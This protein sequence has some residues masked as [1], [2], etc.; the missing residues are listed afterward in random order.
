MIPSSRFMF[1]L[2]E[3]VY[4]PCRVCARVIEFFCFLLL[5][6][7]FMLCW[8]LWLCSAVLCGRREGEEE[9]AAE[10][11]RVCDLHAEGVCGDM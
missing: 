6:G 9:Q 10:G 11:E 3:I 8:C 4:L 5:H 2:T 1:S 7:L